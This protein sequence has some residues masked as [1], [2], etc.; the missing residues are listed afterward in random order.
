MNPEG[1]RLAA[2]LRRARSLECAGPH[3]LPDPPKWLGICL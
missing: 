3:E 2:Y 1:T